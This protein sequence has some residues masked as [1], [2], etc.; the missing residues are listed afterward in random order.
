MPP[1][2]V[3]TLESA[4][5][6]RVKKV[7]VWVWVVSNMAEEYDNAVQ[8]VCTKCRMGLNEGILH[9]SEAGEGCDMCMG[10]WKMV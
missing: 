7:G 5:E 1:S 3:K 10:S 4:L 2:L 6:W 9:S 8:Q